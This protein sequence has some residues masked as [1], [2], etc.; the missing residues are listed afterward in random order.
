MMDIQIEHFAFILLV[1]LLFL[2]LDCTVVQGL[3]QHCFSPRGSVESVLNTDT[4]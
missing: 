3:A 1:Y 4:N 2:C